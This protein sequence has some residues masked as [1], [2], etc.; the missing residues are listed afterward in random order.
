M[1]NHEVTTRH[2]LLDSNGHLIEPGWSRSLIQTYDRSMIKKRPTRIKEWDYYYIMSNSNEFCLCLTIS[3]L[4]YLGMHSV[5]FVDLINAK[6]CTKSELVPFP[7]GKTGLPSTSVKGDVAFKNK[8]LSISFRHSGDKR[9]IKMNYPSFDGNK[10]ISCDIT[11]SDEPRD[12][13]VIATPWNEDKNAFYYNQKI[14][15]MRASG[16]VKYGAELFELNPEIDFAG[17]DWGRGVWTK[18]NYW[19]WGSGSGQ[20]DGVPF[21]FNLGYGFGNTSAASKNV[22]F[23]DGK[24]NKFD[25]I[26]FNI[27]DNYTDA[28][29]IKSSDGRF[30]MDFEPIIDRN[31]LIDVKVIMTDQHQVFGRMSGTAILDDGTKIKVKDFLCFAEKVHNRY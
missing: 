20:I 1:R 4:G 9:R 31:A 11:L 23:Y 25:D 5:S 27:S 21:G 30:D 12:S 10:G 28:W 16:T 26:V 15:C 29:T 24:A 3:D 22:I 6:E 7:M 19:Y 18:D 8:N 14:N 2:N 17:L 13:M